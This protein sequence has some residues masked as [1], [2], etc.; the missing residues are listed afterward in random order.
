ML[1]ACEQILLVSVTG[2]GCIRQEKSVGGG[3]RHQNAVEAVRSRWRLIQKTDPARR[4]RKESGLEM[5][6]HSTLR[7]YKEGGPPSS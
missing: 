7:V 4:R 6:K 3:R 2:Y 5:S 1:Q